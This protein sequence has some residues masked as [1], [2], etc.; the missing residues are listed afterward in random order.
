MIRLSWILLVGTC[1]LFAQTPHDVFEHANQLY[2][3]GNIREARSQYELILQQGYVDASLYYNLGNCHYRLGNIAQAILAYERALRLAP[4]D[5]DIEYNLSL[6]N[7]RIQDRIE[8]LP[9]FFFISWVRSILRIIPAF[10]AQDW[11]LFFW[12]SLFVVLSLHATI[13]RE[14]LRRSIRYA[15][16]IAFIGAVIFGSIFALQTLVAGS[17]D[18]AIIIQNVVTVKSSPDPNS[19]DAFVVHEGLKV[20]VGDQI[21]GWIR[22]TLADG[23]VGWVRLEELE[24]I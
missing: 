14:S 7:S 17:H 11:F 4:G 24:R 13:V 22:V 21:G 8:S 19:V 3:E 16:I 6:A 5:P 15:A 1:C 20:K 2:R 9:E 23:K 18:E 10:S 12:G